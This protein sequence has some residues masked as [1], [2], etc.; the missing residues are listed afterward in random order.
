MNITLFKTW[1]LEKGYSRKIASDT[2]SRLRKLNKTLIYCKYSTS[3]DEEYE[4]D[5][6]KFLLDCFSNMGLNLDMQ[7]L[8]LTTL[9]IGK[10]S[11]HTYKSALRKYL[12]FLDDLHI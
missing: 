10:P 8:E 7:S 11:I 3:I 4:K 9:P 5:N 2:L 6:C 1:L 12:K